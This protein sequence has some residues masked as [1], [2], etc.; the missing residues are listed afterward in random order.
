MLILKEERYQE[1]LS[2]LEKDGFASVEYLSGKLFVSAPTI[3]R[4][5]SSMQELGLISR[6]HGGASILNSGFEWSPFPVR[7]VTNSE[8]KRKLCEKAAE[9]LRDNITVFIDE[10]TTT[11]HLVECISSFS[12]IRIVT[13]SIAVV[14]LAL[15]YKI[16]VFCLGGELAADTLSFVG[17]SAQDMLS[18]FSMDMMF[19]SSSGVNDRGMIV[20]YSIRSNAVRRIALEYS[21]KTF[22]LC[23]SSKFGK[24]DTFN[25][26]PVSSA[27]FIII[28]EPLPAKISTGTSKLIVV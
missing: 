6:N 26:M 15:K 13:N 23:D 27:D 25:L 11:Q 19:F 4:D 2:I 8:I 18:H 9:Y 3:R 28:D 17:R 5:L 12:N 20:D 16:T 1:I 21:D 7:S 10:S 14:N 22:F 24:S